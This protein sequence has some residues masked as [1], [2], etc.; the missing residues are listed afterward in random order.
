MCIPKYQES[1]IMA[2]KP[3]YQELEH[4]IA[5]LEQDTGERVRFIK[6]LTDL[7]A[8]FVKIPANEIDETD[9]SCS[10]GLMFFSKDFE[11]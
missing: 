5:V 7:S 3:T 9:S 1:P 11:Y 4:K 8:T 10:L 6:L 2:D